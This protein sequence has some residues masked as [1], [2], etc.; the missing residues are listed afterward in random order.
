MA[1]KPKVKLTSG[2][3][4]SLLSSQPVA[5]L[6]LKLAQERTPAG[7][8]YVASAGTGSG[9]ARAQIGA[10]T[11]KAYNDNARNATLLKAL[12]GG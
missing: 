4:A 2:E 1:R 8:G 9:R 10:V 6:T 12:D 7:D 11:W 5:D 3:V